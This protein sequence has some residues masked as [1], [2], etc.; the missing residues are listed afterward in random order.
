MEPAAVGLSHNVSSSLST[1]LSPASAWTLRPQ[2]Y[3]RLCR[4]LAPTFYKFFILE[5]A[6]VD[7]VHSLF[8]KSRAWL[9]EAATSR[10]L[11]ADLMAADTTT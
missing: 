6:S 3:S 4:H 2:V 10:R 11:V 7:N 5:A 1:Y 8:G 9:P